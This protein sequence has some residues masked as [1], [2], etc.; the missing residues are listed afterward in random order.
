MKQAF[1]FNRFG[2][3]V[4]TIGSREFGLAFYDLFRDLL[5]VDECTVFSFPDPTAPSSLLVEG[6]SDEELEMARRL[7]KDYVAEGFRRDPNLH[8]RRGL[9]VSVDIIDPRQI[10]DLEYRRHYYDGPALAQELVV[11]AEVNGTLYYTSFYRRDAQRNFGE[12][13]VETMQAVGVF[14]VKALHRHSELISASNDVH[15]LSFV[16]AASDMSADLRQRTLEYLRGILI[17]SPGKLTQREAEVCA[18]IIMGY[19][20]E[21]ISLNCSISINTVATHRKRAYAKL[22]ISSQNELFLRYFSAV[23]QFQ[24]GLLH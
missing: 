20:T 2:D 10:F 1:D 24:S 21:A 9:A 12:R 23:R 18:G 15:E 7:A 5:E 13:E 6:N 22:A 8:N 11:L 17:S 4:A 3:L 19:S 14:M 16:H